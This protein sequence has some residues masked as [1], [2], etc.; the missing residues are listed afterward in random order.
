MRQSQNQRHPQ[1]NRPQTSEYREQSGSYRSDDTQ[2]GGQDSEFNTQQPN[3]FPYRADAQSP[4]Y[5]ADVGDRGQQRNDSYSRRGHQSGDQGE[6]RRE[7]GSYRAGS[8]R[9]G[10]YR[11]S[12]AGIGYNDD[13]QTTDT[14]NSGYGRT[15]YN[16]TRFNDYPNESYRT[17]RRENFTGESFNGG[18]EPA[19]WMGNRATR[20][21]GERDRQNW[22]R[23]LRTS[24]NGYSNNWNSES[25]KDY[26]AGGDESRRQTSR[27]SEFDFNPSS[28]HRGKGPKGYTRSDDRVREEVSDALEQDHWIDASEIEVNV[29]D[30]IVTLSG[31]VGTRKMKRLAEDCVSDLRG[32]KDVINTIQVQGMTSTQSFGAASAQHGN[33]SENA[34][35]EGSGTAANQRG[36]QGDDSRSSASKGRRIM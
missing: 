5:N 23:D 6:F 13:Y 3:E 33:T 10:G 34:R 8:N 26:G 32:V 15:G 22:N 30:G 14:R 16:E 17:G 20:E 36:E 24:N 11:N 35:S 12:N 2:S 31:Q 25:W 18:Y 28:S 9:D 27:S 21:M 7:G 29:K 4:R 1:G 19:A